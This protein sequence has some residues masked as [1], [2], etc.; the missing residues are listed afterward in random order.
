MGVA[1]SN[2]LYAPVGGAGKNLQM[3]DLEGCP[4]P[5]QSEYWD[6]EAQALAPALHVRLLCPKSM[7]Q[8]AR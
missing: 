1:D 3:A 8:D 5:G 4:G 6:E 7:C 2:G